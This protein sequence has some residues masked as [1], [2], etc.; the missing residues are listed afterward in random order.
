MTAVGRRRL[1]F[2]LFL[3]LIFN[4]FSSLSFF[5]SLF[6]FVFSIMVEGEGLSS[7]VGGES[8]GISPH[9]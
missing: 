6:I 4:F 8:M 2:P 7:A 9:L 1:F 3:F 5:F